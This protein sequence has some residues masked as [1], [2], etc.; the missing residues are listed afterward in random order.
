METRTKS[1]WFKVCLVFAL[2][3]VMAAVCPKL[4]LAEEGVGLQ[5]T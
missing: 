3:L 4:A 2:T 5:E 1:R